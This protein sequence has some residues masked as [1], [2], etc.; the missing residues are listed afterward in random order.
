MLAWFGSLL[1]SLLPHTNAPTEVKAP[2]LLPDNAKPTALHQES[3][4]AASWWPL[5]GSGDGH[6]FP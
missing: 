5:P 1:V 6:P 4:K 3:T 2:Q